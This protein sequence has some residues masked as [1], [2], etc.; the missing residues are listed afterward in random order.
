MTS[1]HAAPYGSWRS[2]ITSELIVS[3]LTPLG[4][5]GLAD[6]DIYWLEGRPTEGGRVTLMR[7]T[8]A[9]QI[10]E[11]TPAPFNVRTRV[12]EYGGGPYAVAGGRVIF[13]HFGDDRLYGVEELGAPPRALTAEGGGYRYA[14]MLVD[15]GRD[16]VI[17]VREDH[18]GDGEAVNTLVSVALEGEPAVGEVLVAGGDFYA[19]PRLSPDGTRLAWLTWDHPNMPWD[20]TALWVAMLAGDGTM[21]DARRVAGGTAESVF[22]PEWS[23]D[24]QLYFVSDRT[25]WWNLYRL[26]ADDAAEPLHPMEAEFGVPQWAFGLATYGFASA[27]QIVCAFTRHGLWQLATI[28]TAS[29]ALTPIPTPYTHISTLRVAPGEAVFIGGSPERFSAVVRLDLVSGRTEELRSAG[30]V[31]IDPQYLSRPEPI[32]FATRGGQTAHAF[33]Y[34]PHNAEFEASAGERPPLL[35]MSHGGPTGSTSSALSLNLQYWT[36]RG[37]AV[38]DVNYGGSAGYGRAY[39]QRLNGQWGIVDVDDCVY[40]ARA[41]V[42]RGLADGERLAITGGSAGGYTTLCAL[43]FR[44]VFA[45]GT[46]HFGISDLEGDLL[47]THKFESRYSHGL[48][49]TYPERQAVYYERSPIHFADQIACPVLFTQGL[50]DKVV[51][52]GQAEKMVAALRAN[53]LPVAYLAFAGEGHGFRRAETIRRALEGELYFYAQVFGFPLAEPVEP[54]VIENLEHLKG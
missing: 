8:P 51:L 6:H 3:K 52:P 38:L 10:A 53:G 20:G 21:R 44:D 45:A 26:T 7:R 25:G 41:L 24:G 5:V 9:E 47:E 19:S 16:R 33:Y 43:T 50:D 35:V 37:I 30:T 40:G 17:C 46:S 34:A 29:G 49:G 42:D 14:D 18:S 4:Q 32:S 15:A 23:P 27:E 1:R 36:S 13:S 39:R 2:P 54:V 31:P 48:V 11:V 28:E 22:Q 12:H